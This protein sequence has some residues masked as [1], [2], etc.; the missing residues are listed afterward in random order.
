MIDQLPQWLQIFLYSMIPGIEAK[1][2]VPIFILEFNWNWW[3]AFIIGLVGNIILVPFGLL[4]FHK[5]ENYLRRYPKVESLM[6][7]FFSRIRR[8]A[9][10][11]VERYKELA[12][13][14]FVAIP[15]PLTGAGLGTLIAYL[16]DLKIV[17]SIIIIFIG[18]V[19]ATTVTTILVLF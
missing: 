13:L 2:V 16:F 8:R 10:K 7:R 19:F 11:K 4:F 18:V 5:V 12:L 17:D 1:V 14:F 9:G 3:N 6:N 15:L